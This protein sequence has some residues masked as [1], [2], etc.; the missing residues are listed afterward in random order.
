MRHP[1]SNKTYSDRSRQAPLPAAKQMPLGDHRFQ[2]LIK[3]ASAY[4]AAAERDVEGEKRAAI[5][6]IKA[7]IAQYG[8]TADDL[9]D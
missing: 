2:E 7:R 5:A 4:F 9:V 1:T 3:V 6:E 8:L